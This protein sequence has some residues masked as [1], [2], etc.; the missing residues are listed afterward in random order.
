LRGAT[1][2]ALWSGH[3]AGEFQPAAAVGLLHCAP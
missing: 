3:A 2:T 1:A